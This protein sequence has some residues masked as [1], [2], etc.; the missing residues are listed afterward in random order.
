MPQATY[1]FPPFPHCPGSLRSNDAINCR[2]A[3]DDQVR[4][5]ETKPPTQKQLSFLLGLWNREDGVSPTI[6]VL[7]S[8]ET[9][10]L[11]VQEGTH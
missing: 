9:D 11:F 5:G 8:T 6:I 4:M 1:I 3:G 2:A 7:L 10:S